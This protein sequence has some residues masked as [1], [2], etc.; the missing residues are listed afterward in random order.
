MAVSDD[1]QR[2]MPTAEDVSTGQRLDYLEATLLT[3]P[4]NPQ[5]LG[6]VTVWL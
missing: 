6:E 2:T 5:L 1:M 3:N 4:S